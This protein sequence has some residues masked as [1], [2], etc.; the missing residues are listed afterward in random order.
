MSTGITARV[1]RR[2]IYGTV[3]AGNSKPV[4]NV[5]DIHIYYTLYRK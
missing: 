4:W 5:L 3:S 1:R 2:R